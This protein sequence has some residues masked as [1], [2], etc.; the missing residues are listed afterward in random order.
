M[1]QSSTSP[2]HPTPSFLSPS[3][4]PPSLTLLFTPLSLSSRLYTSPPTTSHFSLSSTPHS[5]VLIFS[6]TY[7]FTLLP[8]S[9]FLLS[10]LFT[11]PPLDSQQTIQHSSDFL[12]AYSSQTFSSFYPFFLLPSFSLPFIP[13]FHSSLSSTINCSVLTSTKHQ[14]QTS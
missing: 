4:M 3:F 2:P 10:F 8:K 13:F 1:L 5:C 7:F 11:H 12:I 14:P 6:S 9:P